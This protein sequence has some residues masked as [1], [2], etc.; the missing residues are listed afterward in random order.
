MN[1]K[2]LTLDDFESQKVIRHRQYFKEQSQFKNILN[3]EDNYLLSKINT[4]HRL[5]YLRDTAIGRFIEEI[6]IKHINILLHY[7]NSDI[8][9][10][11]MTN[12]NYLKQII[13]FIN[14]DDI[15]IKFSGISFLIE[16][17]NCSKDLVKCK[18]ILDTN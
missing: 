1:V 16:I 7:N 8:I 15:D 10:N 11:F 18:I 5:T 12:K 17:F 9:Q 6:T 14:S 13:D 3:I 4:N 2:Y